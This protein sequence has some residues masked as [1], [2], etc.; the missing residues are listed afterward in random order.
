MGT[1]R[2]A[3]IAWF[4]VASPSSRMDWSFV[5]NLKRY[6]REAGIGEIHLHQTRHTFARMVAK[7]SGSRSET[8]DALGHRH[9]STTRIYVE[10]IA[11]KTD[12]Y[13]QHILE[14]LE[15]PDFEID[16]SL[17]SDADKERPEPTRTGT[18][19]D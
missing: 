15:L 10:S 19:K 6:A 7:R 8:Q 12:R 5:E 18:I 13:S 11:V 1:S 3:R 14:A 4:S 17:D 9:A 16:F 2:R